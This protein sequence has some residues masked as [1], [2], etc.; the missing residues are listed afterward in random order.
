MR[1]RTMTVADL[2]AALAEQPEWQPVSIEIETTAG[3]LLADLEGAL[4][5]GNVDH[6]EVTLVLQ[7][8]SG[9]ELAGLASVTP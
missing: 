5:R 7:G 2:H 3:P 8:E 9:L 4:E 6:G 1:I